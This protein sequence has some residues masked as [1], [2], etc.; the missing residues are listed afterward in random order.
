M[1]LFRF[2]T[3]QVIPAPLEVVWD[4]F[5]SPVNL[6]TITPPYM[7]FDIL[8]PVP[9]KMEPGLIIAYTVRPL[10]N[11]PMTWV[12]EITHVEPLRF[13]VDEQRFGPYRFWHHRHTFVPVEGGV[14]MHDLVYYAFKQP[15]IDGWIN[16]YL[17]RPR[18]EEIFA[19]RRR[20]IIELF[21]EPR[22]QAA[23]RTASGATE[24]G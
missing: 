5:S 2:E 16:K 7:G 9:D 12:T 19:Y 4:F 18:I 3:E 15:L 6:K 13:F 8:T 11:L 22:G 21:G 10:F 17:V 14:W 20:K 23:F 24:R 1:K